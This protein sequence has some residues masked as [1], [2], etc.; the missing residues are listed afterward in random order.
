MNYTFSDIINSQNY[1]KVGSKFLFKYFFIPIAWPF[2][3]IFANLGISPNQATFLRFMIHI[4]AFIFLIFNLKIT[5]YF[6]IYLALVLDC[7]DGQ[8]ARLTDNASYF[9]KFFDGWI[10]C[11]FEISFCIFIAYTIRQDDTNIMLIALIASLMNAL[12]W[13]SLI[14][15]ALHRKFQKNYKFSKLEKKLFKILDER[16][17]VDWYDIKYFIFPFFFILDLEKIFIII[18]LIINSLLFLIYS[19]QKLY[20]GYFV[21]NVH[22]VSSSSK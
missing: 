14:R 16:I 17:L 4:V 2:T 5:G 19:L 13:I 8:I 22:K 18:L 10:D 12:Y 11:I 1:K 6:L 20:I 21:L 3:W 9:G 15:F 7:V